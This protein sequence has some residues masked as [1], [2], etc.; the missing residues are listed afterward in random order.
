MS[1]LIGVNWQ[2]F[3]T[4]K[5]TTLH[6]DVGLI[7]TCLVADLNRA[8]SVLESGHYLLEISRVQSENVAGAAL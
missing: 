7:S 2:V 6:I 1:R 8:E 3:I 5:T 4:F